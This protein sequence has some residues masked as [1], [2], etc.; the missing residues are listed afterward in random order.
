MLNFISETMP[1][2]WNHSASRR[3]GA[4]PLYLLAAH[5]RMAMDWEIP[6][7]PAHAE[8]NIGTQTRAHQRNRVLPP[9]L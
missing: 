7:R 2:G 8:A 3:R 9:D 1:G 5:A 6:R 4:S